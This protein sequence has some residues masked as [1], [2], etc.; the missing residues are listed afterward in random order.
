MGSLR[1]VSKGET[2]NKRQ[3]R[4]VIRL[5]QAGKLYRASTIDRAATRLWRHIPNDNRASLVH[6]RKVW[7]Q[8][9]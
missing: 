3:A 9:R 8:C 6:W 4:K 1:S 2:M 5:A 7:L